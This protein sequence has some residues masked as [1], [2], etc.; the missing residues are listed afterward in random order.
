MLSLYVHDA[1]MYDLAERKEQVTYIA[2][3]KWVLCVSTVGK[4]NQ[5][6]MQKGQERAPRKCLQ[7]L[8]GYWTGVET[9]PRRTGCLPWVNVSYTG[10]Q[11]G[12]HKKLALFMWRCAART[13]T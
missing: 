2:C 11:Q 7:V 9:A 6:E 5:M 8:G 1:C 10:T 4:N 13:E 12:R 3:L